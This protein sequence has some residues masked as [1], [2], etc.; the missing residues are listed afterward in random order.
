MQALRQA[1]LVLQLHRQGCH[2]RAVV[3]FLLSIRDA[4]HM[5]GQSAPERLLFCCRAYL[6]R[7]FAG[8]THSASHQ[9][10]TCL[11]TTDFKGFELIFEGTR[12]ACVPWRAMANGGDKVPILRKRRSL[13][14]ICTCIGNLHLRSRRSVR[15]SLG[16]SISRFLRRFDQGAPECQAEAS[17]MRPIRPWRPLRAI[18]VLLGI[19]TLRWR[20]RMPR[21]AV[22]S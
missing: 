9:S 13:I 16:A 17:K 5:S 14:P 19:E 12:R 8:Q 1:A 6:A 2:S 7:E 4:N 18:L 3:R 15:H 20:L 11:H 21:G 22:V 10:Q